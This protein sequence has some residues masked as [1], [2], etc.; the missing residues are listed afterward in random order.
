MKV[1]TLALFFLACCWQFIPA[2]SQT[3]RWQQRV[4][5]KMDI[6]FDVSTHRFEGKQEL[7]YT[8]NSPDT[9]FKVFYHLY[10]NAF[11]PGSAMDVR[12]RNILDPDSRVADRIFNLKPDEIGYHKINS[13]RQNGKPVDYAVEG[14]I[15][16]V[17]LQTPILPGQSAVFN[18]EFSSQVPVQIRRSGR[19]NAEGIDYSM[20]QWYPKMCN[21]DYQG[22]HANPYIAREFYGIWGDFDVRI[23]IDKN[24]I[25]GGTGYLQNRD[26]I[27]HGYESEG[28]KVKHKGKTL[29]WHFT[30]PNVHDFM[31]AA[32]PDY[33]H[34]VYTRKDGIELHC[35][36]QPGE[37]T[38]AWE[39]LPAIMDR[40]LDYIQ[41]RYGPYPYKQYSFVQGGDGGMEYPMSTLITGNRPLPSLVG[42]SIHEL[43]HT[44]YQMILGSNESLYAW[45]DEGFTDYT[46]SEVANYLRKEKILP[47]APAAD[48]HAG[49]YAGYVNFAKSGYEEPLITHAD[50]FQTNAAYAVGSYTKGALFLHQ[51]NYIVG[52][53]AFDKG[54]LRYYYDWRFKHP[55]ANDFIRVMEKVSG[56]ELDWYREYWVN[57]TYNIDY[58]VKSVN[59]VVGHTQVTLQNAGRMPMPL[60]VVVT[61]TDG[62]KETYN[63][64]LDIMRGNKPSESAEVKYTVLPDWP[65]VNPDYTFT[66]EAPKDKIA[67]I[68]IDPSGR[69]VD[70]NRANNAFKK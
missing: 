3:D 43:M 54:M 37:K 41:Q 17:D 5:Y 2:Y 4:V 14:T 27:G 31:W 46:E 68:V 20:A 38:G 50:H 59:E 57:T 15:L 13:L 70:I 44:W 6:D 52:R 51:L 30:A 7:T 12:S 26:E 45:M 64:A 23:T 65:W 33:T 1:Q 58:L 39:Q 56:L 25:I 42:V 49:Q 47:G 8:N 60:D 28:V 48:P 32:D 53:T 9:L 22:W 10:F 19:D 16:E 18:M 62:R 24:Y 21:Y 61:F 66:I 67:S 40:A 55:N 36:Y 63:I 35:F 69:M 29:T 34:T 11:Q